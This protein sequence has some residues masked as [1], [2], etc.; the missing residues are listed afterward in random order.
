MPLSFQQFLEWYDGNPGGFLEVMSCHWPKGL[1]LNVSSA[2]ALSSDPPPSP[3]D[4]KSYN[5]T[6]SCGGGGVHGKAHES[7][8]GGFISILVPDLELQVLK[9]P[10]STRGFSEPLRLMSL[11]DCLQAS[12]ATARHSGRRKKLGLGVAFILFIY[13][14]KFIALPSQKASGLVTR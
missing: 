13:C 4:W 8:A 12:A 1:F 5:F 10:F 7:Y 6:C 9:R 11:P 2:T 14:F 3:C